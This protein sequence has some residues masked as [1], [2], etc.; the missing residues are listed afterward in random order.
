MKVPMPDSLEGS[1]S[2]KNVLP[3]IPTINRTLKNASNSE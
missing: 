1:N 2:S 3:E